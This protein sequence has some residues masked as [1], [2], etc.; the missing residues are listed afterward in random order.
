MEKLFV[1]GSMKKNFLNHDRILKANSTFISAAT[2]VESYIMYPDSQYLFPY[3]IELSNK[4]S[5]PIKGEIYSVPTS[6]I[7]DVIDVLE[8]CPNFYYR[9]RIKVRDTDLNIHEVYVYFLNP[10][11]KDINYDDGFQINEWILNHQ[12]NGLKLNNFYN[13]K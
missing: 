11:N 6:Y 5:F 9:K 4:E 1:Y 10:L 13:L 7:K 3:M 12:E 2:T 8:G